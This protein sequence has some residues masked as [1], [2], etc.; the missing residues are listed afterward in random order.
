M[1]SIH[2]MK[3]IY[4]PNGSDK[5]EV[6]KIFVKFF[7]HTEHRE[8][9]YSSSIEFTN[10]RHMYELLCLWKNADLVEFKRNDN[11]Y[12]NVTLTDNGKSILEFRDL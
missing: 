11:Q 1:N 7:I 3:N 6:Y 10:N 8:Y 12:F 9:S 5:I 4:L 2:D